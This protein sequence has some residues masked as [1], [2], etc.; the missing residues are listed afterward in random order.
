GVLRRP[1]Q[2]RR[3][4]REVRGQRLHAAEP[5]VPDGQRLSS[6]DRATHRGAVHVLGCGTDL[7]LA[8]RVLDPRGFFISSGGPY[9]FD[10]AA[11]DR[12][13]LRVIRPSKRPAAV[14]QGRR[15]EEHT[16]ELQSL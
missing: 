14:F 11:A 2:L 5:A 12:I 9:A 13:R 6:A 7:Q 1:S 10:Y 3:S 8:P 16:S 15:S 4:D